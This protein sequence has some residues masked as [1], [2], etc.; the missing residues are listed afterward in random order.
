MKEKQIFD[1]PERDNQ[2]PSFTAKKEFNPQQA[3]V[4]ESQEATYE[5]VEQDLLVLPKKE[6]KLQ[7]GKLFTWS[8]RIFSLF[9]FALGLGTLYQLGAS[10]YALISLFNQ[11]ISSIALLVTHL[12]SF[13]IQLGLFLIFAGLS[14][15]LRKEYKS[16]KLLQ[17]HEE[18]QL[19]AGI[20]L[21]AYAQVEENEQGQANLS[22]HQGQVFFTNA[23][24]AIAWCQ[25]Q[26]ELMQINQMHPSIKQ[27]KEA[28]H[29][30][31]S[32]G[33]VLQLF[34]FYVLEPFDKQVIEII[35]KR[36]ATDALVIAFSH[37]V[38]LDMLFICWRNLQL[39]NE[40]SSLYGI[41]LGYYARLKM[42]KHLLANIFLAGASEALEQYIDLSDFVSSNLLSK[43]STKAAQGLSIGLLSVRLGIK[44]MEFCRPLPFAKKNR[45]NILSLSK[46]LS[47]N[48]LSSLQKKEQD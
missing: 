26:L 37:F 16:I 39:M 27:W 22:H 13:A 2:T 47:K 15:S 11:G 7:P 12:S 19:Q 30:Y 20:V 5:Q 41:K 28:V 48:L 45:P 18:K 29:S 36:A 35:H 44:Q 40:I 32:P 8:L 25:T 43:F 38:L 24:Q 42:F 34:S 31:M 46:S 21:S 23:E 4:Q 3:Q 10:L 6:L 9:L 1:A 17:E 33:Q 14:L